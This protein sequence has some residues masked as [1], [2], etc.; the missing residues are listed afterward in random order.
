MRGEIESEAE[1]DRALILRYTAPVAAEGAV[2][3][4]ELSRTTGTAEETRVLGAVFPLAGMTGDGWG[5]ALAIRPFLPWCLGMVGSAAGLGVELYLGLSPDVRALPNRAPF[6]FA[7]YPATPGW[8]FR[9]ALARYY[10]LHPDFYAPR[11]P[12][13]GFWNW[14]EKGDIDEAL[15]LYRL[16]GI[17]RTDTF[18]DEIQRNRGLGILSFDY[19]IVGQRELKHLPELPSSYEA[20]MEVFSAFAK[21]WRENADGPLRQQYPHWRDAHLPDLIERCA[22]R[23]ADGRYRVRLRRSE[24]ADNSI[25][26]TMNPNPA[27]FADK[28]W[29]TVGSTTL[30]SVAQWFEHVPID[31]IMIDSLGAEWPAAL[32]FRRD[33]FAYAQYPLTFDKQGRIALHNCTSHYEFVEALRRLAREKGKYLFANG[34]YRYRRP[35]MPEHFN[36]VENGRFFLAALL[37]AAGREQTRLLTRQ[38]LEFFRTAMGR[39]LYAALLYEWKD[40]EM[41][42]QQLNR[43]LPFVVFAG[44]NRHFMS[45]I[46]YLSS[47]DG[48]QRDR[49]LLGWFIGHCRTLFDAGWQ[50]VTHARVSGPDVVCERYGADDVVYF[51]LVSFGEEPV[52]CEVA[53]D[54][55]AL[56]MSGRRGDTL[57]IAEIARN[58]PIAKDVEAN[59]CRVRVKLEPEEAQVLKLRKPGTTVPG[60]GKH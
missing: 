24:W 17:T 45:G 31:G 14:Q 3:E 2:F 42:R 56:G 8:G 37:D 1:S 9:S 50:P 58:A 47:K 36:G 54:L 48:Y 46:S 44:P 39:K 32:N 25:T 27:L 23:E 55:G 13:S 43:A 15:A 10:E 40:P 60:F 26:F 30:R 57:H 4:D 19:I 5:V 28:A 51:A 35:A 33:H 11:F 16:Q 38:E 52:T 53:I 29:E 12:G 34:I 41:V 22:C 7:I 59:T 6:E 21:E 20:A 18:Y 49:E